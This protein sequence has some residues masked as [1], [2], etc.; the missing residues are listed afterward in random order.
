M[1]MH[2]AG[3]LFSPHQA[4]LIAGVYYGIIVNKYI[5]IKSEL[6]MTILQLSY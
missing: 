5:N 2:G 3:I 4:I 1:K 6:S